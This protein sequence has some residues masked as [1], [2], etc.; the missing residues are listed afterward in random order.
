MSALDF[1]TKYAG[2]RFIIPPELLPDGVV[3][4]MYPGYNYYAQ[5]VGYMV[6]SDSIIVELDEPSYREHCW[7]LHD[8]VIL[9]LAQFNM[10]DGQNPKVCAVNYKKLKE[11]KLGRNGYPT[12][13]DDGEITLHGA[14]PPEPYPS[15]CKRC[16]SPARKF[17][18]LI[19]CSNRTCNTRPDVLKALDVKYTKINVLRCPHSIAVNK[20]C[21]K[22]AVYARKRKNTDDFYIMDCE[23]GHNF[24]VY[25]KDLK[26]NDVA[27]Y[28]VAGHDHNDRIW[29][30][31]KWETY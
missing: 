13:E 15:T 21:G 31:K 18:K 28:T 1:A 9:T 23:A 4:E 30:G 26:V 16:S 10:Y 7:Q 20:T 12:E 14:T 11:L 17:G 27:M 24:N 25:I 19:M 2:S 29:N 3:S 5:V 8:G 22:R 6:G